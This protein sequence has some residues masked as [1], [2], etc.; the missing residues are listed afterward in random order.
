MITLYA[1]DN[2]WKFDTLTFSG[3]EEH[4]QLGERK[5]YPNE[6]HVIANIH[7]AQDLIQ[8]IMVIDAVKS[9]YPDVFVDL[10][11][12]YFPYSRQDRVC[13]TGQANAKSRLLKTLFTENFVDCITTWDL[14]SRNGESNQHTNRIFNISL[15]EI[16]QESGIIIPKSH[17]IVAP[18]KGAEERARHVAELNDNPL[19]Q[20][21]KKRNPATGQIEGM[22]LASNPDVKIKGKRCWIVD[23]ICDGGYTF[24]L[25]AK[26]LRELGAKEITLL[27]THG[28]FSK[29][30]SVFDGLIDTVIS[31]NSFPAPESTEHTF[32][33]ELLTESLYDH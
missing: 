30:L 26:L 18:D 11:M 6:V 21:D 32:Y 1:D 17:I 25:A 3:G 24:V 29:G 22:Q 19:I 33:Q 23:D 31:T 28:I 16:V 27:V 14:H 9:N 12:P 15:S 8:T 4:I 5:S 20:L 7:N 13:A 2:E 10:Y